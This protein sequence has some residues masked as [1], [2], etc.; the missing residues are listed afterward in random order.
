VGSGATMNDGA[1]KRDVS[2]NSMNVSRRNTSFL[3]PTRLSGSYPSAAWRGERFGFRWDGKGGSQVSFWN[4][5]V[6]CSQ[7]KGNLPSVK[8]QS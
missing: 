5:S 7:R 8:H 4:A 1:K 3:G 6:L 2:G